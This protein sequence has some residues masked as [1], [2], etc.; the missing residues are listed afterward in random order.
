VAIRDQVAAS[1]APFWAAIESVIA[2]LQVHNP[3]IGFAVG[4]DI[5]VTA[6]IWMT[7]VKRNPGEAAAKPGEEGIEIFNERFER[8]M[9]HI[10]KSARMRKH[11]DRGELEIAIERREREFRIR[12]I[13]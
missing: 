10:L 1:G 7:D 3:A 13:E 4:V 11:S 6:H 12:N 8:W 9:V 5:L 2:D